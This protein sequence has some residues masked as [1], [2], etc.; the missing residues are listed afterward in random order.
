MAK[1][2][3][4]IDYPMKSVPVALLWNYISTPNGLQLW[5]ADEVMHEG[6]KFTF[7]WS[8]AGQDA[9]LLGIRTYSY[10]RF[11]W[12]NESDKADKTYFELRIQVSELTDTTNLVVTDFSELDEVEES[13]ILWNSQIESLKRI[14]GCL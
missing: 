13:K 12:N 8:G 6:K 1:I 9:T 5:F 3:Y 2:K 4:I 14:L 11:R 7:V 10:V